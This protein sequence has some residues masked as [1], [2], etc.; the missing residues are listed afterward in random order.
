MEIWNM[1]VINRYEYLV[2]RLKQNIWHRRYGHIGIQNLKRLANDKLVNGFN[3]DV[4]KEID[5][6]KARIKQ[7]E[8]TLKLVRSDVCGKFHH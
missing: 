1:S 8:E 7:A 3:F 2:C 4:S 5:I 6:C